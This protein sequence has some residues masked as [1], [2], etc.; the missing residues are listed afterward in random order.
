MLRKRRLIDPHAEQV[1]I[2][3]RNT[4]KKAYRRLRESSFA[5]SVR[6]IGQ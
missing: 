5:E 1:A 2:K 6:H 3:K 4:L